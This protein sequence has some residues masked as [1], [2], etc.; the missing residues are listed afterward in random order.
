MTIETTPA[1]SRLMR[2]AAAFVFGPIYYRVLVTHEPV[3]AQ[4]TD[5]LVARYLDS[6]TGGGS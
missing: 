2:A 1:A 6:R 5:A 3:P 4:F